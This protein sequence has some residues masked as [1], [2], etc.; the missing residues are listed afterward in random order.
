M[1]NFYGYL[2]I[3]LYPMVLL[4]ASGAP[5]IVIGR[6]VVFMATANGRH[7][8]R[9]MAQLTAANLLIYAFISL[10]ISPPAIV[11]PLTAELVYIA[12]SRWVGPFLA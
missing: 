7:A 9:A 3:Y 12:F 11:W 6:G 5:D 1:N 4:L 2:V 8:W 10:V